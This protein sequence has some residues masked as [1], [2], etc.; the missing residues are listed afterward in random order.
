[1]KNQILFSIILATLF[2]FTSSNHLHAFGDGGGFGT[3][4]GNDQTF[5]GSGSGSGSF[6]DSRLPS[7]IAHERIT[8]FGVIT[9][10]SDG[11]IDVGGPGGSID[12]PDF[13][14][15]A[16]IGNGLMI[17]LLIAIM[18]VMLV[19]VRKRVLTKKRLSV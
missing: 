11:G 3:P 13:V 8:S 6:G 15:D 5:G 9:P 14:N 12:N 7:D 1:M 16:P 2:I 17:L 18:H 10:F 19:V 4:F